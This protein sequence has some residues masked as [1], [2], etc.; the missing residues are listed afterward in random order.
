MAL[1][2][3]AP[4]GVLTHMLHSQGFSDAALPARLKQPLCVV[5]AVGRHCCSEADVFR[6]MHYNLQFMANL[7][8]VRPRGVVAFGRKGDPVKASAEG[9][10]ATGFQVDGQ[11]NVMI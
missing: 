8:E 6:A 9:I 4:L 7:Q 5:L 11:V 3:E 2:A 10:N 1:Q